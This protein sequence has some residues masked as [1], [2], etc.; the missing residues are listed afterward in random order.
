MPNLRE[1]LQK[2][3]APSYI[4][5]R[6]LGGG[7][8]SL[9]FLAEET[10]LG[11]R[12]A[13]KVLSQEIADEIDAA[14]FERE[15][16]LA[17]GLQHPN[18]VPVLTV[19][20]TDG[21][22]YY[23]MPFVEGSNLRERMSGLPLLG[24]NEKISIL[25]DTAKALEY[26]HRHGVVHRDIKPE[27]ILVTAG[28]AVVVDF[29]IAK[30][31]SIS[32]THAREK[33]L[34]GPGTAVGT[35][36][37]MAPEQAAG[38]PDVD[39]HADIYTWGLVAYELLAGRHPFGGK[40]PRQ[41]VVAQMTERPA[42]LVTAASVPEALS[43]LVMRCLAKEPDARPQSA[44]EIV[45]LLDNPLLTAPTAKRRTFPVW[46]GVVDAIRRRTARRDQSRNSQ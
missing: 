41:L 36:G 9:I 34:T 1:Q 20:E 35:A 24:M 40:T 18:I 17:A 10:R 32:K 13:I 15:I 8:M 30:A 5:E 26:A 6:E 39:H 42:D 2:S 16:Q 45:Q 11:R 12:V 14:R 23:T 29:G 46:R 31:I 21:R 27:N 37:Y 43:S 19:G 4:I 44:Q 22:P 38:E 7:G 33:V 25:R 3:L 28:S